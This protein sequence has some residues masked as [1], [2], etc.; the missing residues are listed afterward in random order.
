VSSAAYGVDRLPGAF[1]IGPDR[2]LRA[3]RIPVVKLGEVVAEALE[4]A[5]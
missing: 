5:H 3:I 2:R 1:L 4:E